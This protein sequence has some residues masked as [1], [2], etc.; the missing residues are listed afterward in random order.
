MHLL[1]TILIGLVA[2]AIA[3]LIMPGKDPGGLIITILLGI[4]ASHRLVSSWAVCWFHWSD[5]WFDLN[6]VH[7]PLD[8]EKTGLTGFAGRKFGN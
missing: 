6:S 7:L 1:W 3:K 4:A 2:G 8:Q 5:C